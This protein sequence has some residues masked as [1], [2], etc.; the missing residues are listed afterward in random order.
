MCGIIAYA[1]KNDAFERIING[2]NKLEYRGYDSAGYCIIDL[3]GN[4][5][6]NKAS[7]INDLIQINFPTYIGIGHTRWATHGDSKLENAHPF[8]DCKREIA[9][10]HNGIISNYNQ[11]RKRLASHKF[12]SDTDSEV[13]VHLLEDY[14]AE[15]PNEEEAFIRTCK[16]LQG[17]FAIVALFKDKIMG[18]RHFSPLVAG[19]DEDGIFIA[20]DVPSFLDYTKN[21]IYLE[22]KE[23]F[24]GL[25]NGSW[26]VLDFSGNYLIKQTESISYESNSISKNNF[27]YFLLKEIYDQ[28]NLIKLYNKSTTADFKMA[29][30]IIKNSCDIFLIGCGSSYNAA[31]AGKYLLGEISNIYSHINIASEFNNNLKF[32]TD[33]S[34]IIALSQS[35][36]TADILEAINNG[37]LHNSKILG[38]TNI[39]GSTLSRLSDYILKLNAG[40]ELSVLAT[41]TYTS[42]I[43]QLYLLSCYL[44]R[45]FTRGIKAVKEL[46]LDVYNLTSHN[47]R[48][49]MQELSRLLENCTDIYLIGRGLEYTTALEGALKIKEVSYIHAE[50]FAGGELKHGSL[51]LIE[52]NTPCIALIGKDDRIFNNIAEIKTRGGF[53]IGIG[54]QY[55][56]LFDIWIKVKDAGYLN[57]VL[58]II[59]LQILAYELAILKNLNPDK[60]RNLAKCVTVT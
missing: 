44:G 59:P 19:I 20:S 46:Y 15:C 52:K 5:L 18:V 12:E 50:A 27:D 35:G 24:I 2:L 33:C 47:T 13:I 26:R 53:I 28:S 39:E 45:D 42:E 56:K 55:S 58:Q 30:E 11:L 43:I 38:I 1:G 51:A 22:D 8:L 4:L 36:E 49:K 32:L 23:I 16:D 7:S 6:Q 34:L 10:A 40:L 37:K 25:K 21:V 9:I 17:T 54:E 57:P 14:I 60:P 3:T 29:G 31:L 48:L 41:K